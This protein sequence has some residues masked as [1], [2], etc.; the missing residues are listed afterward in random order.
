MDVSSQDGQP[1][2]CAC[3]SM[4]A[5]VHSNDNPSIVKSHGEMLKAY[6][7]ATAGDNFAANQMRVGQ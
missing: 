5:C 2:V 3:V 4:C 1:H 6:D 7:T